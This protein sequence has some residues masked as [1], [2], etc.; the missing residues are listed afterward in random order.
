MTSSRAGQQLDNVSWTRVG[1][2][3]ISPGEESSVPRTATQ[4][5]GMGQ[6]EA[7]REGSSE[8]EG[9][10]IKRTVASGLVGPKSPQSLDSGS[11]VCCDANS[12]QVLKHSRM[13]TPSFCSYWSSVIELPHSSALLS[14]GP[15]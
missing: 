7:V 4:L 6:H 3:F 10:S 8:P 11:G 12:S 1:A 13:L 5:G 15:L 9:L 14:S 2:L